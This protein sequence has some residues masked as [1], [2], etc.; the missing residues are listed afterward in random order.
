MENDIKHLSQEH[1]DTTRLLAQCSSHWATPLLNCSLSLDCSIKTKNIFTEF[2]FNCPLI[3]DN[4]AGK[5]RNLQKSTFS[6]ASDTIQKGNNHM[7]ATLYWNK[8]LQ[9]LHKNCQKKV[10]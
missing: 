4:E 8:S 7:I 10:K 1:S 6:Q 5:L 9:N 3:I 2:W